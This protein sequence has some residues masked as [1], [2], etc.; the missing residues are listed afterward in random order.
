MMLAAKAALALRDICADGDYQA[1][2]V[3]DWP[4]LQ[5][6]P[7][8]HPGA[9]FTW[10]EEVDQIPVASEGDLLGAVSQLAALSMIGK[11][12]LPARHDGAGSRAGRPSDVARWR[13]TTLSR[14]R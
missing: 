11:A 3:S 1:L 10:L 8:K 4:A 12:R 13:R 2:A 14:Q 7:G 6:D 9:A 5:V